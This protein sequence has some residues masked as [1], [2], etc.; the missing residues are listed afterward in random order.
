MAILVA[1]H[2]TTAYSLTFAF[3]LLARHP[4][5]MLNLSM[6]SKVYCKAATQVDD[7][8]NLPYTVKV[9]KETLRLFPA[10]H[11][12]PRQATQDTTVGG[13]RCAKAGLWE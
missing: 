13:T 5:S 7:L 12:L 4:P 10:A 3:Y 11:T 2:E 9:F 6:K 8:A 1:G